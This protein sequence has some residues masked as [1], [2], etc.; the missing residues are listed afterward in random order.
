VLAD[1]LSD[2]AR[3]L[4]RGAMRDQDGRALGR[5]GLGDGASDPAARAGDDGAQAVEPDYPSTPAA[6][7]WRAASDESRIVLTLGS[8]ARAR[9]I[10]SLVAW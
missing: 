3:A 4:G 5:I 10:D 6:N 7:G 2:L 1:R 8:L 9:A